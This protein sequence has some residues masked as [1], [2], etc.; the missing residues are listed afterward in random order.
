MMMINYRSEIQQDVVPGKNTGFQD[1]AW[2][3]S[4]SGSIINSFRRPD[5]TIYI[6]KP[7][8]DSANIVA[9][10]TLC[11]RNSVADITFYDSI[12]VVTNIDQSTTN[13]FPV[14]FIEKNRQ[15][16]ADIKASLEKKLKPGLDL[17]VQQFHDEWVI[18]II[19]IAAFL[20]SIVRVTSKNMF[21]DITR[22]FL[23]KGITDPSTRNV[24]GLFLWQSTI[25]NLA[26]F[27]I[28]ALFIYSSAEYF[29]AVPTNI[30]GIFFWLISLGAIIVV[31]ILRHVTCIITG[32]A[33]GE[34]EVFREYQ[35]VVF[36]SYRFAA[37]LLSVI[38][39]MIY[40]TPLHPSDLYFIAGIIV[41][42]IMYLI[43]IA[44]LMKIF[45]NRNIS[46]FYLILYLCALE[47]LPVLISVKYFTSLV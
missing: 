31:V 40:Y 5:S 16:K 19:L 13:G 2:I 14:L 3:K 22:F 15:I 18:G 33:S 7:V 4:D 42:G 47:I 12:N 24:G 34:K 43:R 23:F 36:Q 37:L 21:S 26:S 27:F 46:I 32:F 38:V 39:I 17:P 25:L 28:I 20:L 45:L 30:P 8:A 6:L 1:F 11:R 41:T 44:T 35:V 10:D 9:P 29:G